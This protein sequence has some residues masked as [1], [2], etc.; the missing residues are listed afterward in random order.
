MVP[1]IIFW[2]WW[3]QKIYPPPKDH[4]RTP[5]NLGLDLEFMVEVRVRVKVKVIV[6]NDCL[7]GGFLPRDAYA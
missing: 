5:E 1:K 3:C 7:R 6:S 4:Q 2:G